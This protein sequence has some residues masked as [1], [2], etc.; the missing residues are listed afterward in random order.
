MVTLVN[1]LCPLLNT[2][3]RLSITLTQEQHR[4]IKRIAKRNRV[5][6][7]W[8]VRDAVGQYLEAP[9]P[10]FSGRR[11]SIRMLLSK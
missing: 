7:A 10:L 4:E 2:S 1:D 11:G 9:A 5:S 8:I 3:T 6:R